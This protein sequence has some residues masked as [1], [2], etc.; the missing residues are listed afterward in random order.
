VAVFKVV[1]LY[2]EAPDA[3]SYAAHVEVCR[4]VPGATFRHGPVFGSPAGHAAHAYYAEW[5]LP[6]RAAFE[7]A[8]G[9]DEF[10]A[11]GRD[12]RDRG[13]PR[14]VAVEFLELS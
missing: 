12:A 4:L 10:R 6:D 7:A 3:E 5:E 14:P 9:S 13:L 8:T 1:V 11:T 2:D